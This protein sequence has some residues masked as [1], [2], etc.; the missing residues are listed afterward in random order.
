ML[1]LKTRSLI[2]FLA[3]VVVVQI[4]GGASTSLSVHD[5]YQ[6]L[7]KPS[8]NP[9]AWVFG[10]VW[11]TLYLMIA[12]S[13]WLAYHAMKTAG[14]QH[15]LQTNEF[16]AYFAQIAANCMWSVVFFAAKFPVGG[17]ILIIFMIGAIAANIKLFYKHNLLSALLL[18]PYLLW[19]LYASTLNG[20]IVIFNLL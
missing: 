13:G 2:G 6:T 14:I 17:F 9:P 12:L 5:W 8:W 18:V 7:A 15:P 11:T 4:I 1:S 16:K 20:A 19:V 3:L 10:P